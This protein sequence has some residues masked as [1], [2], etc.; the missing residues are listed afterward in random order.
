MHFICHTGLVDRFRELYADRLEFAG[1]RSILLP[2][3]AAADEEVLAH[4]I[5]IALT[6]HNA[7]RNGS[8]TFYD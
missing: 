3:G 4:C 7:K 2:A 5:S 1:N 8:Y 6:Y